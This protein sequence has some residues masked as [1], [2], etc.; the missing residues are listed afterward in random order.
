MPTKS[1][2]NK[3]NLI[4]V[5]TNNH[6][7][8]DDAADYVNSFFANIGLKLAEEFDKEWVDDLLLNS[9]QTLDE[10]HVDEIMLLSIIQKIDIYC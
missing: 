4:D 1:S 10:F 9:A 2:S 3:I 7:P 8:D 5:H 6:V